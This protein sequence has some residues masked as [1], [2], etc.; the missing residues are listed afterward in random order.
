MAGQIDS[1]DLDIQCTGKLIW[2]LPPCVNIR[3]GFVDQE[4]DVG[5]AA[6]TMSADNRSPGQRQLD[7]VRL[8]R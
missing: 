1:N 2:K 8:Q 4:N 3:A 6:P 5:P 7:G